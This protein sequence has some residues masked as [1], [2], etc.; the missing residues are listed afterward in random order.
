MTRNTRAPQVTDPVT[1]RR[2]RVYGTPAERRAKV[3]AVARVRREL[4]AGEI[5]PAEAARAIGRKR[6]GRTRLREVWEAYAAGTTWERASRGVWERRL[7]PWLDCEVWEVDDERIR[8][9]AR[10]VAEQGYAPTTVRATFDRLH[11]AISLGIRTGRVSA[12]PWSSSLRRPGV[13][14]R[15]AAVDDP[16]GRESPRSWAEVEAIIRAAHELGAEREND[17]GARVG[18][19]L[20]CGLRQGEGCGL[21]W[22]DVDLD[23]VPTL[24][25]VRQAVDQWPSRHPSARQPPDLPKGGHR[26]T[27]LLSKPA[28]AILDAQRDRLRRACMFDARGPVFPSATMRPR[29]GRWRTHAELVTT[30][31]LRAVVARAG[32]PNV[33]RWV[34]HS[35]RHGFA[36]TEL[37]LSGGD[38]RAT[39]Q[40]TGH[41]DLQILA[42]YLH[43]GRGLAPA[44]APD[45][46]PGIV[47]ASPIR[48]GS[49]AGRHLL[50]GPPKRP[51]GASPLEEIARE[52]VRS[53]GGQAPP[54]VVLN[55][56]D[57]A[58]QRARATKGGELAAAHA[59]RA[60]LIAWSRVLRR[61]RA[62]R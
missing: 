49:S 28:R 26:R 25:V 24:R 8:K 54:P 62:E 7:E 60:T 13:S 37:A 40:R 3:E 18:T 55:M 34:V 53:G 12:L 38:L 32:L 19:M 10:A 46:A 6:H 20:L 51:H 30:R 11:A 58:A 50:P 17:L 1:R 29:V 41:G 14:T 4:R 21:G 43:A 15:R 5:S 57:A 39:Q 31:E 48:Q 27:M 61:V 2:F 16:H 42:G 35:L 44:R 36:T 56:A 33:A 45:L 22:P 47:T 52:H 9:W 23:G 59:R